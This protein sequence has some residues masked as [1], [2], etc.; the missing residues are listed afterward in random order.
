MSTQELFNQATTNEF[1]FRM[2]KAA[3]VI[4]LDEF[5]LIFGDG[6]IHWDYIEQEGKIIIRGLLHFVTQEEHLCCYP[7]DWWQHAKQRWFPKW[8][9]RKWPVKK[10]EVMV[11]HKFPELDPPTSILGREFVS[12]RIVDMWKVQDKIGRQLK[13]D[14]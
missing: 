12:L 13:F 5:A 1:V 7:M 11:M 3:S 4:A 14:M 10:H 2:N 9:L 8:A 6:R